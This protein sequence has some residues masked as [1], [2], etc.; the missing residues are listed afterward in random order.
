[1]K[2][3]VVVETWEHLPFSRLVL[4]GLGS[5]LSF[6]VALYPWR[7]RTRDEYGDLTID[8][9]HAGGRRRYKSGTVQ[10]NT[11][12]PFDSTKMSQFFVSRGGGWFFGPFPTADAPSPMPRVSS[13]RPCARKES[14]LFF[15]ICA[16][17]L[18]RSHVCDTRTDMNR[19]CERSRSML[20]ESRRETSKEAT[21]LET[22]IT[23]PKKPIDEELDAVH[24]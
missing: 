14:R 1:M 16:R 24:G 10:R 3:G 23:S 8:H 19:R 15:P 18:C 5:H 20:S 17:Q 21:H 22:S 2:E 6:K 13:P 11:P 9:P 12:F 7:S 4:Y